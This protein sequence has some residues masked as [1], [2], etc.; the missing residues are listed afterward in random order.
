MRM[1]Q[2]RYCAGLV[3][4]CLLALGG[5][6]FAQGGTPIQIGQNATGALTAEAIIAQYNL[7]AAGGETAIIQ[8]L[9]LTTG[10]AP[11]FSV[12][13]PQGIEIVSVEN[14][15]GKATVTGNVTFNDAGVYSILVAGENGGTGQF[16]LS[17]QPGAPPPEP[18]LLTADQAVTGVVGS[19]TPT[20]LYRL[21]TTSLG[22]MSVIVQSLT[23][24]SGPL[25][26][27]YDES[28]GKTIASSGAGLTSVAYGLPAEERLYRVEVRAEGSGETTFSICA[29]VCGTSGTGGTVAASP[30]PTAAIILS[31]P[32]ATLPPLQPMCAGLSSAGGSVN[33]RSGPGT[34]YAVLATMAVGQAMRVLGVWT[35]GAWYQVSVNGQMLWVAQSV[36]SLSGGCSSLPL[37]E[38]PANAPLAPTARPNQPPLVETP[39]TEPTDTPERPLPNL[40]II[41]T[42]I[43]NPGDG[44]L[45]IDIV[46]VNA[47][48]A[49]VDN[50]Y[51]VK[52]CIDGDNCNEITGFA[53]G[54]QPG[55][56]MSFTDGLPFTPT[57]TNHTATVIVDSLSEVT[58]SNE[59]DNTIL[60]SFNL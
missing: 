25:V 59:S 57:G 32:T 55:E 17:L 31:E 35:G 33:L 3:L 9:S 8:V 42:R 49:P 54:L 1:R 2:V 23:P 47:G 12:L 24:G 22:G 44:T 51:A 34:G 58:E 53:A 40:T 50:A 14:A 5:A 48:N 30:T 11:R 36:V 28:A 7:T 37:V 60:S 43:S 39:E 13:N 56:T 6:V 52:T 16:V 19:Q 38:A 45:N 4:L 26:T 46:V 41:N 10:F 15:G 18:T 20:L 21:N 27:L 29:G